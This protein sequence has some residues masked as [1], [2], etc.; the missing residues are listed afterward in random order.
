[1]P[2]LPEVETIRLELLEKLPLPLRLEKVLLR[3]KDLRNQFPIRQ[4]KAFEGKVLQ[5]LLRRSKYLLFD[6]G[7]CGLLSHLG[8]TGNWRLEKGEGELYHHDH[9]R[10]IF[11]SGFS[12]TYQDPR[13]FGYF[14]VYKSIQTH[15]LL[16]KIGPE[17]LGGDFSGTVLWKKTRKRSAPIK[18]LLMNQQIV[19]GVGN[20]YAS[21]VLFRARVKPS[22]RSSSL[23]RE[24]CDQIVEELKKLLKE[25]IALGGS[26]F[27]DFRHASGEKGD[28]QK[29]FSVYNQAGKACLKCGTPIRKKN[30]AGR[31]TFWCPHC[32]S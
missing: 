19:A 15:S 28:F 22:R 9:I 29:Y 24:E 11:E 16:E 14:D 32:Q 27:D 3:R 25:A 31:S 6:F 5:K 23:K 17:P 7:E 8:M 18:N 1:M 4:I 30:F 10:L 21:E 12:L 26:S 20:I 13:R 2:E